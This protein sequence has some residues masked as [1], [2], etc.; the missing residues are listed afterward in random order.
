MESF[1]PTI[2]KFYTLLK[3]WFWALPM[4]KRTIL[5][6]IIG[7]A[8]GSSVI[9]FFNKYA[10][11]YHSIVEGF[12]VPVEGVEY[13]SLAVTL[14]S[15]AIILTSIIGTII[16]YN[17][18]SFNAKVLLKLLETIKLLSFSK[19]SFYLVII[20]Q[21]SSLLFFSV[22]LDLS[23]TIDISIS[24]DKLNLKS[25][26]STFSIFTAIVVLMNLVLNFRIRKIR[27]KINQKIKKSLH[28][29]SDKETPTDTIP[30]REEVTKLSNDVRPLKKSG[31]KRATLILVLTSIIL[32]ISLLFNQVAYK[33][34]LKTIKYG[35]GL[36]IKIEY[37]KADNTEATIEGQLLI[38]TN[39]SLT[40]K[41]IENTIEEIPNE[42][43]SKII[44]SSDSPIVLNEN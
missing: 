7:A 21:M 34:F 38:R 14:F 31:L 13:L 39:T 10:L 42:R 44:W 40:L 6:S 41:T 16:I 30:K 24:W 20:L 5:T 11:Y 3:D 9:G 23:N 12:R 36:D 33:S 32:L 26:L 25:W 18:L 27:K 2:K 43:I 1:I 4:W 17:I 22:S 19:F 15:F 37:R 28:Q 35:G 29:T 8:G